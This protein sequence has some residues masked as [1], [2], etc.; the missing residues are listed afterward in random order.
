V[1]SV[2]RRGSSTRVTKHAKDFYGGKCSSNGYSKCSEVFDEDYSFKACS[3]CSVAPL[4]SMCWMKRI[5]CSGCVDKLNDKD[6]AEA[7]VKACMVREKKITSH[8][9]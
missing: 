5:K 7:C 6:Y 2:N 3:S 9:V 1:D 4:C 8:F